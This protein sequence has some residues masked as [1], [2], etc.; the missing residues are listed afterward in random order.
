MYIY[1][2]LRLYFTWINFYC[3]NIIYSP[4]PLNYLGSLKI[5]R[6]LYKPCVTLVDIIVS[7][8]DLLITSD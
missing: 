8:I 2:L 3:Y 1:Y 5:I 7:Q 4:F 6:Q